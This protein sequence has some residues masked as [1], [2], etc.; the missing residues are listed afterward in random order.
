MCWEKGIFAWNRA[1]WTI[2]KFNNEIVHIVDIFNNDLYKCHPLENL[3]ATEELIEVMTDEVFHAIRC[4]KNGK[5]SGEDG[6]TVTLSSI[7]LSM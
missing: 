1:E 7:Y 6:T 5:W 4:M 3:T 2:T